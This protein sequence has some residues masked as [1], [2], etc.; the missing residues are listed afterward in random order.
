MVSKLRILVVDPI[1]IKLRN[2]IEENF[3]VTVKHPITQQELIQCINKYDILILR[4]GAQVDSE[5]L[6]H[7]KNLRAIIRAGTGT[8]NIDL[9]ALYNA[10]ILFYNTPNTN[11]RAVAELSIGLMHCLFRHIKR[12]SN[13]IET[14]IW[15]KKSLMGFELTNKKLGLIGFGSIGQEIA[16]I[17]KGYNMLVS[18]T[19]AHYSTKRA[20][21]MNTKNIT[22][23][24]HLEELMAFNDILV[25]CCPYTNSTKNLINKDNLCYLNPTS[26]LIN[27]AR[28]GVVSEQDL[29][30]SL[31]NKNIYGAASDVFE[32]ERKISPLFTLNNFI[33]T[34]HIGAMTNESQEKIAD[35]IIQFLKREFSD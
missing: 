9:Q 13:E 22:L 16:N 34:P 21:D 32:H 7:G 11:S 30:H 12:A 1:H 14:N 31:I 8:D 23:F 15:N 26:I 5:L 24:N 3:T 10:K 29:Y 28:G 33:G 27:V 25:V 19:V 4:S 35:L 20:A 2:Y 6:S 18:C 17:A